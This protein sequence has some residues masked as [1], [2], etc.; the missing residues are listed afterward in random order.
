MMSDFTMPALP[1]TVG[2]GGGNYGGGCGFG[3]GLEGILGLLV[4]AGMFGGFGGRGGFG[5]G[6]NCCNPCCDNG[7]STANL[8]NDN[9]HTEILSNQIGSTAA[10]GIAA[11]NFAAQLESN[12]ALQMQ[13]CNTGANI[14]SAIG[15][16]NLV[17]CQGFGDIKYGIADN[18]YKTQL[19]FSQ[20]A[21][22]QA[23]CCCET[24]EAIGGVKYAIAD[25][26][27][28]L[29][30]AGTANTYAILGKLDAGFQAIDNHL[31]QSE[32]Q[33]LRDQVYKY[34]AEAS[35]KCQSEYIIDKVKPCPVPAY[36]TCSPY[37]PAPPPYYPP[38]PFQG[39]CNPCKNG[40]DNGYGYGYAG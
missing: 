33:C 39:G 14:S 6:G 27:N 1:L 23:N 7:Y 8:C 30:N 17:N 11:T 38:Y 10:A 5:G 25:N 12:N 19:G 26:T 18:S 29:I 2:A 37:A 31:T 9:Y 40:C 16:T 34:Q 22:Q 32:M 36:I 28:Q 4:I 13:L 21:A 3:G 15:N 24:R 35:N 20:L